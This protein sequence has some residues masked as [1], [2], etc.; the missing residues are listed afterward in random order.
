M[1]R[2][3][4]KGSHK[5]AKEEHPV[6]KQGLQR[7]SN[8]CQGLPRVAKV[9]QRLRKMSKSFRGLSKASK[10]FQG[11][12][13]T[14][15]VPGTHG[16]AGRRIQW[17]RRNEFGGDGDLD[18]GLAC[19]LGTGPRAD[20]AQWCQLA[21]VGESGIGTMDAFGVSGCV[22]LAGVGGV[23]AAMGCGAG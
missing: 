11:I 8:G 1:A 7:A 5:A 22:A 18:P 21:P 14:H 12:A 13:A 23:G 4:G 3:G 19:I 2:E 15:R 6:K 9:F 16:L 10:R 17:D 20:V